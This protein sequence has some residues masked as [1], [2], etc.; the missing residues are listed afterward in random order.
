M[1]ATDGHD[2]GVARTVADVEI[3]VSTRPSG[4]RGRVVTAGGA[5]AGDA[6]VVG[7]D[8]D[9]RRWDQPVIANTFM[10]R[11][12]EDGTWSID[13]LRPGPY[14]LVAVSAADARGDSLDDPEYLKTLDARAR[15]VMLAEGETPDVVLVVQP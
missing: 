12:I 13:R 3:V 4:A 5:P 10:V 7:F 11:P 9:A 2:F 15:T 6:I 1:D 14:R 8:Q